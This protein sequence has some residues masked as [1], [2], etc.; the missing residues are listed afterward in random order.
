MNEI[1]SQIKQNGYTINS[2]SSTIIS[3]TKFSDIM[4]IE[5]SECVSIMS[6]YTNS[7]FD[8][9]QYFE[10]EDIFISKNL[11]DFFTKTDNDFLNNV[12]DL[13]Y[14]HHFYRGSDYQDKLYTKR[15]KCYINIYKKIA[16]DFNYLKENNDGYITYGKNGKSKI[17]LGRFITTIS[18][19]IDVKSF[20]SQYINYESLT[21]SYKSYFNINNYTLT[22]LEGTDINYGYNK[23]YYDG[24]NGCYNVLWHS[25]MNNHFDKLKLYTE[26]PSKVNLLILIDENGK[27]ISRCFIWYLKDKI[28]M[29]RVYYNSEHLHSLFINLSKELNLYTYNNI[30]YN[31]NSKQYRKKLR[32][33]LKLKGIELFPYIDSFRWKSLIT[34]KFCNTQPKIFYRSYDNT[35][36][37]FDTHLF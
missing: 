23:K 6:L 32:V 14:L 28:L 10:L 22:L 37:K 19:L 5:D 27:I 15:R 3:N 9:F 30:K 18:D 29:D 7:P 13:G 25:C 8:L 21:N 16:K 1:L 36:G 4:K 26:N 31:K 24:T 33:D 20:H 12:F 34:G 11:V 2:E 35:D 17:K